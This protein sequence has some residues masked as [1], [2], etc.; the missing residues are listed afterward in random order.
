M[1]CISFSLFC[2]M[3]DH[4]SWLGADRCIMNESSKEVAFQLLTLEHQHC[5]IDEI[6]D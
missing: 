6:P 3:Q 1:V 5:L 4:E 2:N